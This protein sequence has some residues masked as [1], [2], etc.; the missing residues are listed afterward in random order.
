MLVRQDSNTRGPFKE[1]TD[2]AI[3]RGCGRQGSI[4]RFGYV[5]PRCP[6]EPLPRSGNIGMRSIATHGASENRCPS[7]SIVIVAVAWPRIIW[8]AFT[9][10][11]A[12][13]SSEAAVWR[14]SWIVVPV[15]PTDCVV[16]VQRDRT[17]KLVLVQIAPVGLGNRYEPDGGCRSCPG[18]RSRSSAGPERDGHLGDGRG[19]AAESERVCRSQVTMAARTTAPRSMTAYLSYRVDGARHCFGTL[20]DRSTTLRPLY[21]WT[22]RSPPTGHP[23]TQPSDARIDHPR[24]PHLGRHALAAQTVGIDARARGSRHPLC[25]QPRRLGEQVNVEAIVRCADG[26]QIRAAD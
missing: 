26:R 18:R 2:L 1:G 6:S 9:S 19:V 20:N 4:A 7:R 22:A 11:P 8:T 25:H 14:R 21:R 15:R 13:M 12:A 5:D 10:A 17:R 24:R 3:P 16:S 23:S